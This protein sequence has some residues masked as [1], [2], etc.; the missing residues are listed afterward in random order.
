M[1]VSRLARVVEADDI[2]AQVAL[3]PLQC[4]VGAVHDLG[5]GERLGRG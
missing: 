1:R 2:D 5:E 3:Q 4:G